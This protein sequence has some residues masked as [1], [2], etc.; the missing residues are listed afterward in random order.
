MGV[1]SERWS[2]RDYPKLSPDSYHASGRPEAAVKIDAD[3]T[4]SDSELAGRKEQ[5]GRNTRD[6]SASNSPRDSPRRLTLDERLQQEH[7]VEV[8]TRPTPV[9]PVAGTHPAYPWP[10]HQHHLQVSVFPLV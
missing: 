6:S 7:G 3:S 1:G 10:Y 4:I 9:A 2:S 5:T 8:E